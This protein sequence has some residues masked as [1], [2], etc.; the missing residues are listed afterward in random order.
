MRRPVS[1]FRARETAFRSALV[2]A[3]IERVFALVY[4]GLTR[5]F[6]RCDKFYAAIA[7]SAA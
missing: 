2:G 7:R 4:N 6:A 5:C 3:A 1:T